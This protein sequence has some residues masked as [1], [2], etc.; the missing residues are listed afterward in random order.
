MENLGKRSGAA[1]ASI[2]NRVQEVEERISGI[3]DNIG[4]IDTTV[5]ENSKHKKP[6]TQNIHKIQDTLKRP[7]LSII[8]IKES[9]VVRSNDKKT[10]STNSQ[11]K[12]SLSYRNIWP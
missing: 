3:E 12:T 7:N 2:T 10:S 6:L 8:G 9:E 4:Y 5:K 11:R 1:D